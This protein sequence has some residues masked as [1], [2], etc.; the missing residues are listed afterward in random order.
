MMLCDPSVVS[1]VIAPVA[2]SSTY[3]LFARTYA[4]RPPSGENFANISVDG[5]AEAPPSLRGAPLARSMT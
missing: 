4:T 5:A 2:T 1:G 3:R